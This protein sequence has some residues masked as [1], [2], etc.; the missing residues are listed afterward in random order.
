MRR[1]ICLF[2][3]SLL[4]G[5]AWL[6]SAL[7]AS[8]TFTTID[9]PGSFSTD[10]AGI[11][12]MGQIVG[13]FTDA[14]GQHGYL[15]SD[16]SFTTI[17]VPGSFS[18]DAGGINNAGQIV[19]SFTDAIFTPGNLGHGYLLSDGSFTTIDVP[20]STDA[21]TNARDINNVGQI[22]G[23]FANPSAHGFLFKTVAF[24]LSGGNFTT[25]DVPGS[26]DASTDA[27]GINDMGQIIV[28]AFGRH[29]FLAT[30]VVDTTP[31]A[32]TVSASPT[33]LW[34]P[35]GQ[36]VS[37]T[38]SGTITDAGVGVNANS[39]AYMVEDEYERVHPSGPITLGENGSY[40]FTIQL[41]ASRNGNDK[42]GRQYTI[43]ISANDNAGNPGSAA[44]GVTVPH[45]QG[46]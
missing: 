38:V 45:D 35:N 22:V 14:S 15:L 8:Y 32:I 24:L 33:T 6:S 42:N 4:L 3:L 31:P 21:A 40:S 11:N 36:L 25:I 12:D 7:G 46:H 18:T 30:P 28:G 2:L 39:A 26:T 27:A 1:S 29:G 17:D 5:S 19:G 44:T 43:T 13:S 9:V 34:P 37:V 41:E 10:A 23:R 16:G 20:G